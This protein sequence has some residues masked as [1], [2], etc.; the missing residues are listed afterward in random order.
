MQNYL[1]VQGKREPMFSNSLYP[2][3]HTQIKWNILQMI[4]AV[5]VDLHNAPNKVSL[6]FLSGLFNY[7]AEKDFFVSGEI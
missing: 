3:Q 6:L 5:S 7:L 1:S 4:P 2:S